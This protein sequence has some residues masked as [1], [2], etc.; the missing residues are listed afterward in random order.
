MRYLK[1]SECIHVTM[2]L[3][4]VA[5][6]LAVIIARSTA[7]P[8]LCRPLAVRHCSCI[9]IQRTKH[10]TSLNTSPDCACGS[11]GSANSQAGHVTES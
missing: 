9:M 5:C 6:R 3:R 10:C 11:A 7:L 8:E 1:D 2:D 4:C